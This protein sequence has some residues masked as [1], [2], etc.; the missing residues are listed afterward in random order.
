MKCFQA[1]LFN[2]N[3]F[4]CLIGFK[5]CYLTLSKE[6]EEN[7]RLIRIKRK[8]TKKYE[9][10]PQKLDMVCKVKVGVRE[11]DALIDLGLR[12]LAPKNDGFYEFE[13]DTRRLLAEDLAHTNGQKMDSDSS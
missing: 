13:S 2:K 3:S 8:E 4:I 11:K 12:S 6:K 7:R 5:Y 1:L 10:L 9:L